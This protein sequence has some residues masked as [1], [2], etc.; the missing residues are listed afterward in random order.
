M[1]YSQ[2]GLSAKYKI[3]RKK[4]SKNLPA[5]IDA[6]VIKPDKDAKGN[7]IFT[8]EPKTKPGMT[9]PEFS[10][11]T[12]IPVSTLRDWEK[13]GTL[14]PAIDGKFYSEEQIEEA[15]RIRQDRQ[16]KSVPSSAVAV[17]LFGGAYEETIEGTKEK[18]PAEPVTIEPPQR[19]EVP[20]QM[21]IDDKTVA[22]KQKNFLPMAIQ[23]NFDAIPQ[24]LKGLRRWLCWQLQP[25]D[26]KP[27]KV[28]MSP[29]NGRLV[30]AAVNKPENWLTFDEA[31]S[32]YNR[33]ECSG[34]GFALTNIPPKV[35][36]IDIDHCFNPDGTL[37]D[38]AKDVI[39]LC[40][41]SWVEKS[42]SGKGIHVW[43][44]DD[45]FNGGRRQG[46][47]E[48]YASN[49]YIAMTGNHIADTANE[50]KTV[51]GACNAVVVDKFSDNGGNLFTSPARKDEEKF[52]FDK[53]A[54]LSDD[55]RKLV[56]YFR[57]DEC[58]QAD[59]QMFNL[60]NGKTAEYF[61]AKGKPQNDSEADW[62][63]LWKILYY[64]GDAGNDAELGQ[65][66]LNI[67]N[68]SE[69]A[70]RNKWQEREDY[71]LL[72]LEAALRNWIKNGRPNRKNNKRMTREERESCI[73]ELL[74]QPQSPARD[75]KIMSNIRALC[76]WRHDKDRNKTTIKP[77]VN[78]YR[79]IFRYDPN[80]RG[81][82]GRDDFRQE[83]VF[84]KRAP[85]HDSK[86]PIKDAWD[87]AD[88][89]E[90]RLYLAE[91]YAEITNTQRT[92]DFTLR[93]ARE[94]SF[95]AIRKFFENLPQWDGTPRAETLFVKF[96]G[97][98]DSEYT[99]AVTMHFLLGAIARAFYPGCDFQSVVVLQGAQGIGKSRLVRMLGGKH[100]VS[101]KDENW[102]VA[103]RDS[104]DDS[105]AIDA[106][107]KGWIVEI[108]EFSAASRADV[109]AMKGIISADD[110][111]RRFAYDRRAK[112]IKAHWVYVATSNDD[113]PLR[114]QTGNRR[115]LPIKCHNKESQ[116]VDGMTPEYIRQVW[117][118]ALFK[119]KEL[120]PTVRKTSSRYFNT[121][122][123]GR[124]GGGYNTR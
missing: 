13:S 12:G 70:K 16:K 121:A 32:R 47:V 39:K 28:P 29:K 110:I 73:A 99:R 34:I 94:N 120:F 10:K 31:L 93:V 25:A 100:G 103:L 38:E 117:A 80:L 27:R 17:S 51:K 102:H 115:F 83:I 124:K 105:H 112:T 45:D 91:Y 74:L 88:D 40:D 2:R 26:P 82:F 123:S 44:I 104:L 85:W 21:S 95:H 79:L 19:E 8:D 118:E 84:F 6:G 9:R 56:D 111:T 81:L 97:A 109:N 114:D 75:E 62:A 66:A 90:L 87:D 41:N 18:T 76:E 24:F 23:P 53:N 15:L 72:T 46:N 67:F 14:V 11:R 22:I 69:L 36:C 35:C 1:T 55:D 101:Y 60:F 106:M 33:G 7:Y 30:N 61:K 48:I 54:P 108:E 64:I 77:T 5:L 96:L 42:Q 20:A 92:L 57:S 78:N 86:L 113:S 37:T 71:R 98:D 43:F 3:D 119:F 49:R 63:L 4:L 122:A 68:Q 50:I 52:H 107:R 116:I 65:R 89:A 59:S 58:A